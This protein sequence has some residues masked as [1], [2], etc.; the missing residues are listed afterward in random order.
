MKKKTKKDAG[1]LKI[2]DFLEPDDVEPELKEVK[3]PDTSLPLQVKLS[4]TSWMITES[5]NLATGI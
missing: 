2:T 3:N 4:K 5:S 1:C